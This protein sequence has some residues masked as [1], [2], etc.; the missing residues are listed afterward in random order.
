MNILKKDK[1]SSLIF[2]CLLITVISAIVFSMFSIKQ[3][4]DYRKDINI[5]AGNIVE[6]IK[7]KYPDVD[8]EE[9]LKIYNSSNGNSEV[10]EKYGINDEISAFSNFEEDLFKSY[11]VNI[12]LII[13]I[14]ILF[15]I[16]FIVYLLY[17][18]KK[19][20]EITN[21]IEEINNKNYNL[22]ISDEG[23][24]ELSRLKSELCKITSMLKEE[25]ENNLKEKKNLS[26]SVSDI[27]HQIKTPLTSIQI[28]LDNIIDDKNMKEDVKNDFIKE[29]NKQIEWINFL[30]ISLLKLARF[31]A[32][33]IEFKK[34][35]IEVQK[36]LG[37]V[38]SNLAITSE[39]NDVDILIEESE[40]IFEGDFNW[41]VEAITN[42][43]KNCIEHSNKGSVVELTA[44]DNNFYV[45]IKIKDSGTGMNKKDLQN[46]FKRFYKGKNSSNTSIGIGLNLAKTIIEKDNG[47]ITCDSKENV[48]TV[49][50]IKYMKK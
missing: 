45:G 41:Q 20:K 18:D 38:K 16:V 7:E 44:E 43:V 11:V 48:G 10:L 30:V 2:V 46:I 27:S 9:I 5:V 36:L 49:F 13:A 26:N 21:Y 12:I 23:E 17:R 35:K 19:I 50:H 42:I 37:K 28:M 47:Y 32:G 25:S 31:D 4:Y 40:A 1:I 22:K 34:E 24:G 3:Y 39:I 15:L 14:S 8:E 6:T 29:I 33:V